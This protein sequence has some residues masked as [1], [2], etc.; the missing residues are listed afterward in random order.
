MDP[1]SPTPDLN[2][3]KQTRIR[4]RPNL[5]FLSQRY[6]RKTYYVL[7]DPITLRYY[8]LDEGQR[9][10]AG[11][12]DGRRTLEEIQKAYEDR[13]RPERLSLEELEAFASQLIRSGLV[14]PESQGA[15]NTLLEH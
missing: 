1:T 14:Q 8:R 5:V 9:F 6:E 3:R 4:L 11:L 15:G 2:R 13:F 7:K 12:M 10:A